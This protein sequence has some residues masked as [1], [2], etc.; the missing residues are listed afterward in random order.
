MSYLDEV[1]SAPAETIEPIIPPE[2]EAIL[3]GVEQPVEEVEEILEIPELDDSIEYSGEARKIFFSADVEQT[4]RSMISAHNKQFGMDISKRADVR[5]V[6]AVYRRGAGAFTASASLNYNR[7]TWAKARVRSFLGLLASGRPSNAS[8]TADND[9][10]P[11]SHPKSAKRNSESLSESM[12]LV[13]TAAANSL[14]A[15]IKSA[16]EFQSP[17]HAIFALAEYSGLGYDLI[18]AVRAVWTRATDSGENPF[19]R[20]YNFVA[21][22]YGSA[23][24]DLLPK[25]ETTNG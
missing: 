22:L 5:A 2:V 24:A 3:N 9:L 16:K 18:P 21:N 11:A 17:E 15:S 12:Q 6:R 13:Q 19:D 1:I 7:D 8:Y 25:Q 4:L 14:V 20:A 23:D 10:L